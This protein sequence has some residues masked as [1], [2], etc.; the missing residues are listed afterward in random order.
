MAKAK[1][2]F[3]LF[4]LLSAAAFAARGQDSGF[5]VGASVSGA[6][7]GACEG[8]QLGVSCEDGVTSVR[9]FVGSQFSPNF[10]VEAGFTPTLAKA[11]A[12]AI[13]GA[14]PGSTFV[15]DV[16]SR[17]VDLVLVPSLPLGASASV[18]GKVG[19][20]A[21]NT[22]QENNF[23]P[24]AVCCSHIQPSKSEETNVGF[25]FGVGL[26][27]NFTRQLTARADW[28]RYQAVGGEKVRE[29]DVNTLNLGLLY[30]F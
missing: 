8:I 21:A 26:G 16:R 11:N 10:A 7:S 12:H 13:A 29:F 1:F 17:A 15:S 6:T 4:L 5:Y 9:L 28:Q 19:V 23:T 27:W 30:R 18:Y 2:G 3:V 24:G 14:A 20:Y 25:T 22:E